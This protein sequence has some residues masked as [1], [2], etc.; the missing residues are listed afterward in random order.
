M[1]LG[2]AEIN[3]SRSILSMNG[4]KKY[5]RHSSEWLTLPS[6]N[7]SKLW[8][9]LN[10]ELT[11]TWPVINWVTNIFWHI[12]KHFV[13]TV[14]LTHKSRWKRETQWLLLASFSPLIIKL[15]K[16]KAQKPSKYLVKTLHP[17]Q[18]T[19]RSTSG[20]DGRTMWGGRGAEHV[21]ASAHHSC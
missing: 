8:V 9:S 10:G 14:A 5:I 1:S 19:S 7:L 16:S 21:T 12:F 3:G 13:K 4:A 11:L 20:T 15:A 2:R 17:V 18:G 6:T